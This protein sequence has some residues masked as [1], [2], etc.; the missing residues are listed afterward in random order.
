MAN[1]VWPPGLPQSPRLSDLEEDPP[2]LVVRTAM[3]AGPAKVRR[4]FTAGYTTWSMS[5]VLTRTQRSLLLDFFLGTCEGGA[6]AFD[7]RNP[8]TLAAAEFRWVER[9]R[10]RPLSMRR[11]GSEPYLAVFTLE[12]LPSVSNAVV[13]PPGQPEL[14]PWFLVRDEEADILP[15]PDELNTAAGVYASTTEGGGGNPGP[16]AMPL[17]DQKDPFGTGGRPDIFETNDNNGGGI[18]PGSSSS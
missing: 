12:E 15:T 8:V 16:T 4:R 14:S 13:V 9:P 6:L 2:N 18:N 3:D 5:L 1:A 17:P 10:I 7:W 11:D